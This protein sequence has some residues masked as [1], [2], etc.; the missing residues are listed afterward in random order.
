MGEGKDGGRKGGGRKRKDGG[1]GRRNG[2]LVVHFIELVN[3]THSLV[4]K[5]KRTPLQGPF[6][7][8]GVFADRSLTGG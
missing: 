6:T 5:D 4:S 2:Y 7:R 1:G 3:K 8:D